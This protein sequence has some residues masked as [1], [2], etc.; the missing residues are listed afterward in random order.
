MVDA[1]N[2]KPQR[3][4]N[5]TLRNPTKPTLTPGPAG[6]GSQ[7]LFANMLATLGFL[8]KMTICQTWCCC[9]ACSAA[10]SGQKKKKA[11][12]ITVESIRFLRKAYCRSQM[13]V[14]VWTLVCLKD[15]QHA[16]SCRREK[17]NDFWATVRQFQVT[18]NAV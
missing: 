6:C 9:T 13:S 1:Y 10:P 11:I 18:A 12:I 7:Q 8:H 15:Q 16:S 17:I 4:E 14:S 5:R 2:L 3:I